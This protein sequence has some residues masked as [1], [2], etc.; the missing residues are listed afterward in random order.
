M[1]NTLAIIGLFFLFM[2]GA[3]FIFG[4]SISEDQAIKD[5]IA[6]IQ[7][8][9][10][11]NDPIVQSQ[12]DIA[13]AELVVIQ[14]DKLKRSE[15]TLEKQSKAAEP[16]TPPAPKPFIIELLLSFI[17]YLLGF[18]FVLIILWN[19]YLYRTNKTA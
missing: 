16:L 10:N 4:D 1:K 5:N 19:L 2:W 12:A 6:I 18:G 13:K 17:P 8:A 11:S 9:E 15:E 14:N 3:I 7:A